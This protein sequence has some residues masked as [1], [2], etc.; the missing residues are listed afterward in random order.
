M[1]KDRDLMEELNALPCGAEPLT[2]A[3]ME[4]LTRTVLG[5]VK[6][7]ERRRKNRRTARRP[8]A[9]GR[10]LAG[11]AAC[12]CL[13]AGVN[14]V[15][16]ALAE[17]LPL[18]GDVFAYINS[19]DKAPLQSD[20]M[21]EVARQA[22]VQAQNAP[23]SLP[24]DAPKVMAAQQDGDAGTGDALHP[25]NY[26]L[27]LRQIY[28]D[29]LYLRVGLVLT[30]ED[31]SLAGFDAVT[32]DPP[33]LDETATE[34]EANA[35]YGGVTLNGQPV[36]CD[37]LPRFSKQ[38]DHTFVCELDYDLAGYTGNTQDMQA[39][40]TLSD[41]VGVVY[42]GE[43]EP[44]QTPLNGIYALSFTVSANETL[45]RMGTFSAGS[46]N[47]ITL[48]SVAATPGET[49]VTYSVAP[50]ENGVSPALQVFTADGASLEPAKELR[51]EEG[52]TSVF[53]AYLDAA[54]EGA[55]ELTVRFVDKNREDLPL[56]AEWTV[57]LPR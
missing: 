34:A 15:N 54:P 44:Q 52:G 40:I 8:A 33:L 22:Q 57:T 56:L 26:T 35:L 43:G 41:L 31:D 37:M 13:L 21:D 50:Q 6:G 29:E 2:A 48:Q 3:E 12:I 25:E 24:E 51:T 7:A 4:R 39:E 53:R 17:G 16:P 23:E 10:A 36:S 45:T 55:A 46:Q 14:S 30:A 27:T 18:L 42:S 47:G 38:D 11:A 49:C 19:L 28:C 1:C 32:I 5:R 20:Q 9:W